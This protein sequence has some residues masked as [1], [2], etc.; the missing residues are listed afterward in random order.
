MPTLAER[1]PSEDEEAADEL[2]EVGPPVDSC[3]YLHS[4]TIKEAVCFPVLFDGSCCGANAG[5]ATP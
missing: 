2:S 3:S 1:L 5:R 4:D